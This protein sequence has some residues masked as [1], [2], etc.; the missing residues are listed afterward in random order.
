MHC[1]TTFGQIGIAPKQYYPIAA[2][3]YITGH[4]TRIIGQ[5]KRVTRTDEWKAVCEMR[6]STLFMM[7]G[8]FLCDIMSMDEDKV[9]ANN[10][11]LGQEGDKIIVLKEITLTPDTIFI[12][13]V[14]VGGTQTQD[15][16]SMSRPGNPSL[17][18]PIRRHRMS[19]FYAFTLS[20]APHQNVFIRRREKKESA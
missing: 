4:N 19:E 13:A 7:I 14:S 15:M 9:V 10:I 1:Q 2:P 17:I 16:R 3:P 12:G 11:N 6:Q 8:I 18:Q 20:I 5:F